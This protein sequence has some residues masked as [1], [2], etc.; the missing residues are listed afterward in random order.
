MTDPEF[1]VETLADE[2][3]MSQS[4]LNR[5]IR[6]IFRTTTN[7]FIRDRRLEKAEV[8]LKTT[9]LQINEICYKVGFQTPSYFIKCFR[10][11][12]GCSPNEYAKARPATR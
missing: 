4:S 10:T 5:K 3:G 11:K 7:A 12:Y 9:S 1:S 6:D 2:L 8:L